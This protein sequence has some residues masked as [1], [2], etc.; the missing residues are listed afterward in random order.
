MNLKGVQ[1]LP[2]YY[3]EHCIKEYENP[4]FE[5]RI[6]KQFRMTRIQMT[7]TSLCDIRFKDYNRAGIVSDIGTLIFWIP[8]RL[9]EWISDFDI[10]ISNLKALCHH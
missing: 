3:G 8:A 5:I 10:L 4:N 9:G 1:A 6:S 2:G 7:E